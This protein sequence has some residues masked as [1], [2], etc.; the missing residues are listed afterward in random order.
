M[1]SFVSKQVIAWACL[2]AGCGGTAE[3]ADQ[4]AGGAA[5]GLEE[6]A[7]STTSAASSTSSGGEDDR[8]AS[9]GG[10]DSCTA[11]SVNMD[12]PCEVCVVTSCTAEAL[13]CCKTSGC[14]DIV[15]CAQ[16]TGCSG[17]DCYQPDTCQ[18]VIDA[19]GGVEV[20]IGYAAPLGE[21]AVANCAAE[22]GQGS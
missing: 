15:A 14:L 8:S 11:A 4:G 9:G 18:S 3:T 1:K 7:D 21:C 5:A 12:D 2:L 16:E 13:A 17:V 22:C 10:S 19:S 6:S 20:A